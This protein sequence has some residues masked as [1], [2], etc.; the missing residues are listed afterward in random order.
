MYW[1]PAIFIVFELLFLNYLDQILRYSNA[2]ILSKKYKDKKLEEYIK[3]EHKDFDKILIVI[4][5][6][7]L[8]EFIYFIVGLFYPIWILSVLF[9]CYSIF[10][11]IYSKFRK[12]SSVEQMI[13]L[14]KLKNFESSDV[15]F[16]RLLKLSELKQDQVK[17]R[18]WIGYIVPVIKIF[19]FISIILFHYNFKDTI[20]HNNRIGFYN[21]STILMSAVEKEKKMKG[22]IYVS[23]I[24]VTELNSYTNG[25]SEIKLV[26]VDVISGFD[27]YKYDWVK[28]CLTTKFSSIKKTTDIEWLENKND[29]K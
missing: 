27:I 24:H 21:D 2:I 26:G 18:T 7:L 11:N 22:E 16:E 5:V 6:F 1:I 19:I 29:K 10:M 25:M 15:K 12:S 17:T 3:I 9:I 14:A 8:A 4:G 28:T 20:P 13:K 23:V